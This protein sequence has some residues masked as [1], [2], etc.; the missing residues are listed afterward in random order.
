MIEQFLI[1]ENLKCAIIH[2]FKEDFFSSSIEETKIIYY[3][4]SEGKRIATAVLAVFQCLMLTI[5][6]FSLKLI[7]I[8]F[9]NKHWYERSTRLFIRGELVDNDV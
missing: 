8:E 6:S 5:P 7:S 9:V 3:L 1:L 2:G 4:L